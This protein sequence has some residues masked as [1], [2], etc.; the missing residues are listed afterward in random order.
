MSTSLR[1]RRPASASV[2][3]TAASAPGAAA[4]ARGRPRSTAPATVRRF[5]RCSRRKPP[6]L[7][8]VTMPARRCAAGRSARP[9]RPRSGKLRTRGSRVM[10]R[11]G[12][13]S[14][15][16]RRLPRPR[17]HEGSARAARSRNWERARFGSVEPRASPA[18]GITQTYSGLVR[19]LDHKLITNDG[20]L[21]APPRSCELV[22]RSCYTVLPPA[23]YPVVVSGKVATGTHET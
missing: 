17:G 8:G 21:C 6:R 13:G 11:R 20:Q 9:H 5:A 23:P 2:T 22:H 19:E 12:R 1:G 14:R 4:S 18:A 16:A 7:G 3:A 10:P 15:N